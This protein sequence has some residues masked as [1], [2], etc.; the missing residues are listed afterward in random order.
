MCVHNTNERECARSG[1]RDRD[2]ESREDCS[3]NGKEATEGPVQGKGLETAEVRLG[4][5]A[6]SEWEPSGRVPHRKRE[7]G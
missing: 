1:P 7:R 4:E 5:R 2:P 3:L 6:V